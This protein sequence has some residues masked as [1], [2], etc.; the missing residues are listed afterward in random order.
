[1]KQK[2]SV[3]RLMVASIAASGLL[4]AASQAAAQQ[5]VMKIKVDGLKDPERL[6]LVDGAYQY[7]SGRYADTCQAYLDDGAS[8][9]AKY[10]V[11]TNQDGNPEVVDCLM[12]V[13]GGGWT[14]SGYERRLS[15]SASSGSSI[16]FNIYPSIPSYA[17]QALTRDV[18]YIKTYSSDGDTLSG[19]IK[20]NDWSWSSPSGNYSSSA[21]RIINSL[22]TSVSA[23]LRDTENNDS[24]S[25]QV[26]VGYCFR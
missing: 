16:S 1:M 13:H 17:S 12:T 9:D 4:A 21:V 8:N 14:C 19:Y 6:V 25:F 11:D 3:R 18:N 22:D 10:R 15:R 2:I 26:H 5:Y 23:Y 24:I 20:T 7:S